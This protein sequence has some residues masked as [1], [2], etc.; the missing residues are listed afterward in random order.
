MSRIKIV[1]GNWKMNTNLA[2]AIELANAIDIKQHSLKCKVIVAPPFLYLHELTKIANNNGFQLASQNCSNQTKGAFTGE[3]SA[4]MIKSIGVNYTIIGHSE[5][6]C[7]FHETNDMIRQK[8]DVALENELTPIVCIGESLEERNNNKHFD[9][10]KEQLST[11]LFHLNETTFNKVIIAYEPVWAIGTGLT[12]TPEQAQ[13]IHAFIRS[14]V[15]EKFNNTLSE[16][17]TILYGGSCNENNAKELFSC[18]D[19]DGGLIGGASLKADSFLKIC[20]AF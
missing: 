13:E 2:E 16:N 7:I 12:A 11:A 17:I 8:V 15:S 10:L 1:A 14:L 20:G 5:R 18:K 19:I 9:I 3:V 6:R 4:N